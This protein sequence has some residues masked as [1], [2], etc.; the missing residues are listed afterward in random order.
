MAAGVH[1]LQGMVFLSLSIFVFFFAIQRI[2]KVTLERDQYQYLKD[3]CLLAAWGICGV[4]SPDPSVRLVVAMGLLAAIFGVGQRVNP[5]M[6]WSLGFFGIG[7]V[8]AS[9]GLGISF[10]GFPGGSY[11]FLNRYSSL[12]ATALWVGL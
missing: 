9:L 11:L 2:S 10:V 4:W 1:E 12:L 3:V 7:L 5:K 6:P 8:F